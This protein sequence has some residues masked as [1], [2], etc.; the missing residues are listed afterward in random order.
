[1]SLIQFTI[2]KTAPPSFSFLSSLLILPSVQPPHYDS[3][4]RHEMSR[5]LY[6]FLRQDVY[7]TDTCTVYD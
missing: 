2:M 5:A 6:F 4:D 7:V 3:Y 1:M